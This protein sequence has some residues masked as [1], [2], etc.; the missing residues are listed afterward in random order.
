[1]LE[2]FVVTQLKLDGLNMAIFW[3]GEALNYFLE[4]GV[5]LRNRHSTSG[6]A[7][8]VPLLGL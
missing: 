5:F 7:A 1:M 4:V 6:I 2:K 8:L 3:K